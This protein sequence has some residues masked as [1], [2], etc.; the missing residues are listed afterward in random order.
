VYLEAVVLLATV[1]TC[2][3]PIREAAASTGVPRITLERWERWWRQQ[4]PAS[5]TWAELRARFRAPPPDESELPG[6]LVARV[7]SELAAGGGAST[8]GR[9]VEAVAGFAACLLA[10]AT[11]AVAD[12]SRFLRGVVDR[13]QPRLLAQ[14]M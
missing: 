7:T 11:T 9:V 5:A 3:Q 4:F 14:K 13:M 12:G 10:P 6:S 1:W 8:E 2:A